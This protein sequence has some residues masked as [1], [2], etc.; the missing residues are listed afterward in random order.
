[1]SN[2]V[3]TRFF[4]KESSQVGVDGAKKIIEKAF[5]SEYQKLITTDLPS[6]DF[7][8]RVAQL[9]VDQGVTA[10]VNS[11]TDTVLTLLKGRVTIMVQAIA[12][13]KAKNARQKERAKQIKADEKERA[14]RME[15]LDQDIATF[16]ENHD[17]D[18][19]CVK[20][21]PT[22]KTG[23]SAAVI[24]VSQALV[25][26]FTPWLLNL[27]NLLAAAKELGAQPQVDELGR[28]KTDLE[29]IINRAAEQ[30]MGS[31]V[32]DEDAELSLKITEM[33]EDIYMYFDQNP[34]KTT[35]DL[36]RALLDR[37]KE[38]TPPQMNLQGIDLERK[39]SDFLQEVRGKTFRA[40]THRNNYTLRFHQKEF[41]ELV[42]YYFHADDRSLKTSE[43]ERAFTQFYL[44]QLSKLESR[45]GGGGA[46]PPSF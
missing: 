40:F 16:L 18:I 43:F 38:R 7:Y 21:I 1:M 8:E 30:V 20:A 34:C 3:S 31:T 22:N 41:D 2:S 45:G 39:I 19:K 26:E 6:E 9:I 44:E 17:E 32:P 12:T 5:T 35:K 10:K 24:E 37:F 42:F 15:K 46:K 28:I 14:N 11:P 29:F 13:K 23:L 4:F 36:K 27:N 33:L 25:A